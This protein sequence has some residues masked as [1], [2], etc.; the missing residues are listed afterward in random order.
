M[1]FVSVD[2]DEPQFT[3]PKRSPLPKGRHKRALLR[4]NFD[5]QF[6]ASPA[7]LTVRIHYVQ[8]KIDNTRIEKIQR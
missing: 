3:S 5:E 7:I 8:T 2:F 6:C 1:S 4:T